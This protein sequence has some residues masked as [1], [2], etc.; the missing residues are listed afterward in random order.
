MGRS[1]SQESGRGKVCRTHHIKFA[2]RVVR[3][4]VDLRGVAIEGRNW[5]VVSIFPWG[6]EWGMDVE[7]GEWTWGSLLAH[8]S[9]FGWRC[10]PVSA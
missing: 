6:K 7:N 1:V 4:S 3:L 2:P 5:H 8:I 10:V 9:K